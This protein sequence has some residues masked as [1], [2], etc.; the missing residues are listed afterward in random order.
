[1]GAKTGAGGIEAGRFQALLAGYR[2]SAR[3]MRRGREKRAKRELPIVHLVVAAP[4]P[5]AAPD[6]VQIAVLTLEYLSSASMRASFT[7]KE[8]FVAAPDAETA[9]VFRAALA[10]T[11][12]TRATDR[13]IRVVILG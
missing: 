4:E 6:P 1:M 11:A 9:A 3:R 10:Q 12:R 13:L 8:V 5:P 7:G 2:K